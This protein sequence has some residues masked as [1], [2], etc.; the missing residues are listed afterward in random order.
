MDLHPHNYGN[1]TRFISISATGWPAA[2]DREP[3]RKPMILDAL[4]GSRILGFP[5]CQMSTKL[6][7]VVKRL[8]KRF[9]SV[10]LA[11]G[12]AF[13]KA[14]WVRFAGLVKPLVKRF[15]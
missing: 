9:A 2:R 8:V 10:L 7:V 3:L 15:E 5:V 14:F 12:K 13:G 1:S 11:F 4:L 6:D